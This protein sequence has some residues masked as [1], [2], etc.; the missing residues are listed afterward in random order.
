MGPPP[1]RRWPCPARGVRRL[2]DE[3]MDEIGHFSYRRLD[4]P[5]DNL[6]KERL[7]ATLNA[8]SIGAIAYCPV[9]AENFRDG[10]KYIFAD[11]SCSP[12]A[13]PAPNR[14]SDSD[15]EAGDR[16]AVDGSGCGK[17][18]RRGLKEGLIAGDSESREGETGICIMET[19]PLC[20]CATRQLAIAYSMDRGF[21]ICFEA[22]RISSPTIFPSLS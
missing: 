20:G 19:R 9:T 17:G 12:S 7:I 11:G 22:S 2:L 8:R 6:A 21:S 15:S 3:T 10:F 18:N 16:Q 4:L 1:W 14:C 5:I 13:Y